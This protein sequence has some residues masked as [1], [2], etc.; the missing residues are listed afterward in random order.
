MNTTHFNKR[1]LVT[2][3]SALSLSLAGAASI[4]AD[5]EGDTVSSQIE[6]SWK[7]T[8]R[9]AKTYWKEFKQDSEQTWDSTQAAF[10]DG[11]IEGKLETALMMSEHL[12]PLDINIEVSDDTAYL[13]GAVDS[14][15]KKELAEEIALGVEGIDNVDNELAVKA[16]PGK[17]TANKEEE[18]NS[19]SQFVD[20][21]V[22]TAELKTDLISSDNVKALD[23][24][25]D[26]EGH[27]ITLKGKVKSE[28]QKDL[29]EKIVDNHPDVHY[30]DNQLKVTS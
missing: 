24:D 3:I 6:S 2:V 10:R 13:T 4:A 17:T 5:K 30:I 26:V 29:V 22:L 7:E 16:S 11:W 9:D 25:I 27:N 12:S 1:V 20:D 18:R 23:V 21:A 8:K 14:E 15:I 28:E 19:F